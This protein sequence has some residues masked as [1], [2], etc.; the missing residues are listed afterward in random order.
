MMIQ[1]TDRKRKGVSFVFLILLG[2]GL[3]LLFK[4]VRMGL[5]IGLVLG[6]LYSSMLR[7]K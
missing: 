6:L 4:N 7:R 2:V 5:L 3:G 1:P